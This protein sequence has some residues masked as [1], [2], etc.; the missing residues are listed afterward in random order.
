MEGEEK[1]SKLKDIT[2]RWIAIIGIVYIPVMIIMGKILKIFISSDAY[3][4]YYRIFAGDLLFIPIFPL[5][6]IGFI[7]N[8]LIYC[9]KSKKRDDVI[10]LIVILFIICGITYKFIPYSDTYKYYKDLHYVMQDSYCEDVQDLKKIYIEKH[11]GKLSLK[12]M[13]IETSD[14]KFI[15]NDNLVEEEDYD[16]FKAKFKDVKKVKIR[17]L[18]NTK[19]L[20]SIEPAI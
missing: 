2:S 15:V 12:T 7:T 4:I 17:Y 20:I 9:V 18:P 8:L 10:I 1:K 5:L 14:I 3:G 19:T 6:L 13:Y 16:T 11:E